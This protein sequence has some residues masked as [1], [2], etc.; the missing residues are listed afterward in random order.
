MT[1]YELAA[2]TSAA[3]DGHGGK[4]GAGVGVKVA[5]SNI[6]VVLGGLANNTIDIVETM[7]LWAEF[8]RADKRFPADVINFHMYCT[9]G[10]SQH[11]QTTGLPPE[12]CDMRG[13]LSKLTAWRNTK[14][15]ELE[16]WLTEFGYDTNEKSPVRAPKYGSFSAQQVQGMWIVRGYMAI[17]AAG[18]DRAYQYMLRNV[19]EQSPTQFS[20]SG[21]TSSKVTG[22]IPKFSWYAV[23]TL[24]N[25]IGHM[26]FLSETIDSGTSIYVSSFIGSKVNDKPW[27]GYVVWSGTH[28]SRVIKN[29]SLHCSGATATTNVTLVELVMNSTI[30]KQSHL[31]ASATGV[32]ML[33]EVSEMPQIVLLGVNPE[34][35]TGPV[36]PIKRL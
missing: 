21:L 19:N 24:T 20:S 31:E 10:S 35:V 34:N 11:K 5:D 12:E 4:L 23:S 33:K 3:Y 16:I 25:T 15:P 13:Q 29:W 8:N 9:D 26:R 1:P 7:R 6:K 18:F 22:W 14:T 2:M 32:V 27:A 30:G 17:L 28:N 36:P